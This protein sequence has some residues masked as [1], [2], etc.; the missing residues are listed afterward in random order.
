MDENIQRSPSS[1]RIIKVRQKS[2]CTLSAQLYVQKR[3]C[4][5]FIRLPTDMSNHDDAGVANKVFSEMDGEISVD[6]TQ[7]PLIG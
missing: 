5:F 1:R 2:S 6:E 7:Q 4:C 3:M